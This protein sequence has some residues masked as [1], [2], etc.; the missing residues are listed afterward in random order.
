MEVEFLIYIIPFIILG[1]FLGIF[2][3]I[4]P[5]IHVNTLCAILIQL[6]PWVAGFINEMKW[7]PDNEITPVLISSMIISAAVV[8]SFLDIIPSIFFGAP[9]DP[10]CL[11]VL[12]GHRL[13]LSGKGIEALYCAAKGGLIGTFLAILLAYP[14][15]LLMGEPLK[16]Y[17]H[18]KPIIPFFLIS[19]IAL[20]VLSEKDEKGSS[21]IIDVRSGSI[22]YN[23]CTIYINKVI[24][25][26]NSDVLVS[27]RI[28]KKNLRSYMLHTPFGYWE[29]I[30]TRG[31]NEG[32]A[33]LKGR[34]KFKR[35][36]AKK[37]LIAFILFLSSGI[38]GYV[39]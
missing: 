24:P 26:D 23:P 15:Y 9:G 35:H 5:G 22:D 13:L 10:D 1:S 31:I 25:S 4:A 34:W 16:V 11:S 8:H 3:G 12:P 17:E 2:S 36:Y 29:I 20:L 33:T 39:V 14:L 7:I 27:G 28:L 38:L 32:F 37:K 19:V 18:F 21:A 6:H 30:P